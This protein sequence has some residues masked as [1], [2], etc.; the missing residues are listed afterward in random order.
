MGQLAIAAVLEH[1]LF[2]SVVKDCGMCSCSEIVRVI[3]SLQLT[4]YKKVATPANWKVSWKKTCPC[5][6]DHYIMAEIPTNPAM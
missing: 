5:P 6:C 1:I 2:P 4:A 3:D